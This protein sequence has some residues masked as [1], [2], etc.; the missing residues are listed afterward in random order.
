MDK[1]EYARNMKAFHDSHHGAMQVCIVR[2]EHVPSLIAAAITGDVEVRVVLDSLQKWRKEARQ[3]GGNRRLLCLD[4][5]TS[6]S[7]AKMPTAFLVVTPFAKIS[8]HVMVTG[9]CDRCAS[10]DDDALSIAA[11][12]RLRKIY[13]DLTVSQ[14]KGGLQ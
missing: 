2:H 3:R 14:F 12:K 6:F 8:G 7:D 5:E 1:N 11:V 10:R 4:C 13:P 9:I